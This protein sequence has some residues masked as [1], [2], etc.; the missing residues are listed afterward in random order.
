MKKIIFV[1]ILIISFIIINNLVRS[2]YN[3]WNKQHLIVAARKELM[4]EKENNSKLKRDL[5]AVDNPHFVDEEARNKL[6]MV[7]PGEQVII[8]PKSEGKAPTGE[9]IALRPAKQYWQEWLDIFF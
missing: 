1:L 8:L 9:K 3:L 2:I 6:F 4:V 7:K 5:V